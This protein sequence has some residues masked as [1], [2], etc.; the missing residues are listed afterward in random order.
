MEFTGC[1]THWAFGAADEAT[2]SS[3]AGALASSSEASIQYMP[4][5][6]IC[7]PATL[8]KWIKTAKWI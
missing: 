3:M 8:S 6:L 1:V 5:H 7:L 2:F 4:Q